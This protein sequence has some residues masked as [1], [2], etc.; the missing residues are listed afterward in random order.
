[1][2]ISVKYNK[3]TNQVEIHDD[4]GP[5]DNDDISSFNPN[6][7]KEENNEIKFEIAV[8]TS[9]FEIRHSSSMLPNSLDSEDINNGN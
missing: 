6:S 5:L 8:N 4:I 7:L 2:I 3:I 1:M 9:I